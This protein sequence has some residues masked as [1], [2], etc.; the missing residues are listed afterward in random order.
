V[1]PS[2]IS[3]LEYGG[4]AAAAIIPLVLQIGQ[5]VSTEE[6]A[7]IILSPLVKLYASPD[8]GTRM[9]LLDNLSEYYEKLDNKMVV[10]KI[11]PNLVRLALRSGWVVLILFIANRILGY[12]CCHS[13][14]DS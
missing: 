11:W 8:R 7:T 3:A 2:L 12:R 9:A 4:A 13:R 6:Y 14:S 10:D 5:N 1:L